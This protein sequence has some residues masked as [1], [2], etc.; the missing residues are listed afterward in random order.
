MEVFD[1]PQ[2]LAFDLF[3]AAF[4]AYWIGDLLSS[5][6]LGYTR[7]DGIIEMR[8]LPIVKNYLATWFIIDVFIITFELLAWI[9][10]DLKGLHNVSRVARA[11]RFLR[12][13]RIIKIR[14]KLSST[15]Q[16]VQSSMVRK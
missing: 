12:L 9:M 5:F 14:K 2:N 1:L 10:Q 4:L 7:K 6:F 13:M 3:R 16:R 8:F 11:G 15:Y